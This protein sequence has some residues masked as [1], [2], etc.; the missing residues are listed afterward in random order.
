MIEIRRILCPVDLSDHSRRAFDHALAMAQWYGSR[1][2]V[3]HVVPPVAAA[4][5]GRGPFVVEPI[6]PP[7]ADAERRVAD[8]RVFVDADRAPDVTVDVAVREGDAAD[9]I[10]DL[11]G[12][13]PA[14]L[15]VLGTHGRSGFERLLLGSVAEKVLRKAA[16]PVMTVPKREPDGAAAA[17][18]LYKRILCPVDFSPSSMHALSYALSLAQEADGAL[19]VLHVMADN[20][21]A[22]RFVEGVL[23]VQDLQQA[24]EDELRRRLQAIAADAPDFCRVDWRLAH[25]KAWREVLGVAEEMQSRSLSWACRAEAPQTS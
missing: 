20:G 25:G 1:L 10:L 16:C 4:T 18:V 8:I 22:D 2:T 11:A 9:E 7:L 14:D 13:M 5:L 6:V 19:T 24:R 3:L 15:V 21:D 17:E 12:T 23:P